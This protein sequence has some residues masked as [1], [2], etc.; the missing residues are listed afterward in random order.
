MSDEN[1]DLERLI[2]QLN[3]YTTD[4]EIGDPEHAEVESGSEWTFK[5]KPQNIARSIKIKYRY[6]VTDNAGNAT[7][8]EDHLLIGSNENK[9]LEHLIRQ[10]NPYTTDIEIGDPEHAE[11][12]SGSEW[13]F[14]GKPQNIARSI[15]IKYRYPVTD[16]AGNA[17][18]TED[19]LLIGFAGDVAGDHSTKP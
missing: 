11:V 7:W 4:M 6:T 8:T 19:H 15:K 16:N 5:G 12:E 3:P 17:T 9:D 18:W 2:R 13:T 14:K 1:K 10:R